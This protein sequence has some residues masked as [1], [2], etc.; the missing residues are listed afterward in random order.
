MK[1]GMR[2]RHTIDVPGGRIDGG[3]FAF[4]CESSRLMESES[5]RRLP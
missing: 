5:C 1:T 3:L 4:R 2:G